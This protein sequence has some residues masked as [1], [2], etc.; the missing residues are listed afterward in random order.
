SG[1][2]GQGPEHVVVHVVDNRCRIGNLSSGCR[3][4]V[5]DRTTWERRTLAVDAPRRAP[6]TDTPWGYRRIALQGRMG[7]CYPL[8]TFG[9]GNAGGA[10]EEPQEPPPETREHPVRRTSS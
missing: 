2:V 6:C 7:R 5:P 10:L 1:R 4:G 8:R 9:A 3:D